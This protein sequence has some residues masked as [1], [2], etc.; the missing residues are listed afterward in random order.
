[1][2]VKVYL[3]G[4]SD[5]FVHENVEFT[6]VIDA[7]V[8]WVKTIRADFFRYPVSRIIRTEEIAR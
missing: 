4:Y 3:E 7:G 2:T 6:G 1:M 5:P 8:Y